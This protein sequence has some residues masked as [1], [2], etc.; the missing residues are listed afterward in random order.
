MKQKLNE[1]KKRREFSFD[2]MKLHQEKYLEKRRIEDEV[3]EERLRNFKDVN[4]PKFPCLFL[5]KL[6]EEK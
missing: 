3:R 5:D 4:E 1:H 6:K 2:E